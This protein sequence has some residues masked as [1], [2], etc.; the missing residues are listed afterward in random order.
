MKNRHQ[1]LTILFLLPLVFLSGPNTYPQTK[2][3]SRDLSVSWSSRRES[4]PGTLFGSVTNKSINS[5]PCVRIEF[6]LA[7]RF[8]QRRPGEPGKYLGVLP[9]EVKNISPRT[10]RN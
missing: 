2:D 8:D 3:P 9:V 4:E 6:D 5:Y 7:T 10:V 1:L